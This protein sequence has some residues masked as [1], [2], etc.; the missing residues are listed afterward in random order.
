LHCQP[1]VPADQSIIESVTTAK[2]SAV[3]FMVLLFSFGNGS[4]EQAYSLIEK[5]IQRSEKRELC[6]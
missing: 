2:A 1:F 6:E 5:G 4:A 3:V